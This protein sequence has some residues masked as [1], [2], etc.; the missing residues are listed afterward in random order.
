MHIHLCVTIGAPVE[1]VWAAV[2]D[3]GTHTRWMTDAESI[4]FVTEQHAGVG[5]EFD[6]LTRVGPLRTVDRMTVT[7]WEP[8]SAMGIEHRGLVTGRGRFTLRAAGAGIT[9]FCWTEELT[10]PLHFG[11]ALGETVARPV[12]LR[13]WRANLERLRDLV[14]RG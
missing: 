1:A 11:G 14:E 10:F 4:T 7:E 2:E 13:L 12:F 9:E 5:T 6:C 8:G 3:V